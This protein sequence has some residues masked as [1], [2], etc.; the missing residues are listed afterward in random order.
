MAKLATA[1]ETNTALTRLSLR[2]NKI[3]D[4]G[5]AKLATALEKNIVL[6]ELD[7]TSNNIGDDAAAKLATALE[8]NKK[9]KNPFLF[10]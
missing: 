1:L 8:R 9:R 6:T 4:A 10:F 3:G 7:L 5:A 2:H